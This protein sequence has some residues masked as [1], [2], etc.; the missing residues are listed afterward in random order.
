MKQ[1]R[2]IKDGKKE[3]FMQRLKE[4]LMQRSNETMKLSGKEK[5]KSCE[6]ERKLERTELRETLRN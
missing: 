2:L 1:K 5:N 4:T 3:M 6:I